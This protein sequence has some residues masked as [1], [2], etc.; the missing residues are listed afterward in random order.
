[1]NIKTRLL[2]LG[3]TGAILA[4]SI[5]VATGEV[6]VW[7][8]YVDPTPPYLNLHSP[9]HYL[10]RHSQLHTTLTVTHAQAPRYLNHQ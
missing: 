9:P 5:L 4:G 10:N 1:M 6:E 7:R 2:A 3:F 8:T